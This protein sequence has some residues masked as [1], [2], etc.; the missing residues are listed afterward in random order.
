M[1]IGKAVSLVSAL[2]LKVLL[3]E[4]TS[5]VAHGDDQHHGG[6]HHDHDHSAG[7][8]RILR[9]QQNAMSEDEVIE[10]IEQARAAMVPDTAWRGP[11][12]Q[13]VPGIRCGTVAIGS[14]EGG[15]DS[16]SP[17]QTRR[18]LQT[19]TNIIVRTI[20]HIVHRADGVGKKMQEP[21]DW[22]M[23][24]SR[25]QPQYRTSGNYHQDCTSPCPSL[26]LIISSSRAGNIP[27]SFVND[28][29]AVLNAALNAYGFSFVTHQIQ[30][31]VNDAY[32][33]DC[34]TNEVAMKNAYAVDPTMFLNFYTCR[35]G[36]LL[37]Y[38]TFPFGLPESS[39]L[40]GVVC[41]DQSL[42]GGSASPYNLGDTGTHEVGHYLGMV[43]L[44]VHSLCYQAS[45]FN[46][47]LSCIEEVRRII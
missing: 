16:S 46:F 9:E 21:R 35:P 45:S 39:K 5:V 40:H 26:T 41:L 11:D 30:R 34:R 18:Q 10:A 22:Q 33:N 42:P 3:Q 13:L 25:Q 17:F 44:S 1:K 23:A 31:H 24:S 43:L 2:F 7:V 28:Q 8:L 47:S 15:E 20:Y 14:Q 36:P 38:A 27:D 4:V 32:Y 29:T 19:C 37:G 12:G 6:N